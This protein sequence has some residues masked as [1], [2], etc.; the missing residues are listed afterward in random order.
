[1]TMP[2]IFPH[3]TFTGAY[4]D[5][6][7]NSWYPAQAVLAEGIVTL[8]VGSPT[9]WMQYFSVPAAQ[10]TVKSAAQRITLTVAGRNYP[11]LANPGAVYQALNFGAANVVGEITGNQALGAMSTAGRAMNQVG[12]AQAFN[13]G[14]GNE[15]LAAMRA[16]GARVSRLGYGA[17][18][19]IGCGAG[20][21]VVILVVVITVLTLRI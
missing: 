11:I 4:G 17:I 15:F 7:T 12:A 14:G 10:V 20:L 21:L 1:M 6:A 19:A 3:A 2:S 8:W 5:N 13:A 16:S 9:G 18:A